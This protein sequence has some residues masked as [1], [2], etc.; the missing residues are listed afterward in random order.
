MFNK[1]HNFEFEKATEMR[2]KIKFLSLKM[3]GLIE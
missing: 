2:D 1:V 3:A